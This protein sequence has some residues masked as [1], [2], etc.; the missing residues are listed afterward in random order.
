[1]FGLRLIDYKF[2]QLFLV[3]LLLYILL[4]IIFTFVDSIRNKDYK[5]IFILPFVYVLIHISYGIGMI[6]SYIKNEIPK[7]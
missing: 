2:S 1:M 4:I 5:A 7:S 6:S 3:P